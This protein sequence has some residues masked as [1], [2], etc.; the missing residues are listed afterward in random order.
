[1]RVSDTLVSP[2]EGGQRHALWCRKRRVPSRAVFHRAYLLAAPVRVLSGGLVADE[3][4][5][6]DR[7]L[8]FAKPLK[9]LL[10]D[11]AAQSPLFGKFA[12][13]LPTNLVC[14]G[15]V[16]L[17]LVGELLRMIRLCLSCAQWLGDGQHV[18]AYSK[19]SLCLRI[20]SRWIFCSALCC[21]SLGTSFCPGDPFPDGLPAPAAAA[22]TFGGSSASCCAGRSIYCGSRLSSSMY[23]RLIRITRFPHLRYPC[24]FSRP[25][26]SLAITSGLI[27]RSRL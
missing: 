27:S 7:M 17:A 2:H 4:F 9:V 5:A 13:P 23:G 22:A 15:V 16:V 14:F 18:L 11:L 6:R 24:I 19:K 3:L 21:C 10:A 12:V 25:L 26:I 8:P 20:G 1:M